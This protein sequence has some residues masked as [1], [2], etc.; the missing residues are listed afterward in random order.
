MLYQSIALS[1]KSCVTYPTDHKGAIVNPQL[2]LM[3]AN[4]EPNSQEG[5]SNRDKTPGNNGHQRPI[6]LFR[7]TDPGLHG[8]HLH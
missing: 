4:P 5:P 8:S 1:L 7:V 6:V 3:L 2:R